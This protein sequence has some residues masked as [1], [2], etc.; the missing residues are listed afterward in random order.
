MKV[1][2]KENLIVQFLSLA[3]TIPV[4]FCLIFLR[5]VYTP[6]LETLWLSELNE[7]SKADLVH[8]IE[9]S[10]ITDDIT[11]LLRLFCANK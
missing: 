4:R 10:A 3:R 1:T 6:R 8:A 5:L 7:Q 11:I 9:H 2:T